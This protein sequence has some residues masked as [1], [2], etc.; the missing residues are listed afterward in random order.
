MLLGL[1]GQ[2]ARHISTEIAYEVLLLGPLVVSLC[3]RYMDYPNTCI[4]SMIE[5]EMKSCG[6][7]QLNDSGTKTYS[8]HN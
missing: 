1:D 7:L 4:D 2:T 3:I 5:A 8:K 6:S